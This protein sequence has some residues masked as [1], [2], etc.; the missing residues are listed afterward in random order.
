MTIILLRSTF[1]DSR[2]AC[3]RILF[4]DLGRVVLAVASPLENNRQVLWT[5]TAGLLWTVPALLAI[6]A[7][8]GY[9]LS[10]RALQ[11]VDQITAATRS[12]SVSNLSARLPVPQS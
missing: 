1:R 5:F 8:G 10:R 3:W 4:C 2:I 6:S 9:A 7:L 11:P 12:I